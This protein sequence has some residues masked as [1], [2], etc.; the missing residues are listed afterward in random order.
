MLKNRQ[1]VELS[2]QISST[3]SSQIQKSV[4]VSL[5]SKVTYSDT[6]NLIIVSPV[7]LEMSPLSPIEPSGRAEPTSYSESQLPSTSPSSSVTP[8]SEYNPVVTTTISLVSLKVV[9]NE[10]AWMGTIASATDEWLELYNPSDVSANLNGWV[11]KSSDSSPLITLSGAI[12]PHGYYLIERTDDSTIST[13]QADLVTSFGKGGLG[14]SGEMLVLL[15]NH[16]T[17]IDQVDCAGGWFAGDNT[18]KASMERKDSSTPGGDVQN[19]A[20]ND[21]TV[22]NGQDAQGHPLLATPKKK[23]SVGVE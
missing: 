9:I 10:I 17:V 13:I 23:N 14:N 19:W 8:E 16:G 5:K 4:Q 12:A 22:K 6:E 2:A 18:S 20:S 3:Q 21:G 15:D 1:A 7:S 11:L